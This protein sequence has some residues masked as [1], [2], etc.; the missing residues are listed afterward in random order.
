MF[1]DIGGLVGLIIFAAI[2]IISALLKK[3]EEPFE[4]PPEMD[5][6]GERPQPPRRSW[7]EELRRVLEQSP[8]PPPIVQQGNWLG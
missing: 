6:R 1:A 8:E 2:A 3:K 4:S 5:P 7:E